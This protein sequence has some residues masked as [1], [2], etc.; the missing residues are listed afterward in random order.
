MG[1]TTRPLIVQF[2]VPYDLCA[3]DHR[4]FKRKAEAKWQSFCDEF[5]GPYLKDV[6]KT[7]QFGIGIGLLTPRTQLRQGKDSIPVGLR[8]ELAAKRYCLKTSWGQLRQLCQG[9]YSEDRIR[10]CVEAVFMQ[11]GLKTRN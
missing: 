8:Y 1:I 9:R 4:T 6:T 3:D 11:V 5:M 10:K 7:R 2:E